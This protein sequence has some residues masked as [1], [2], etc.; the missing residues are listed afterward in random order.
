M[1][2]KQAIVNFWS[3]EYDEYDFVTNVLQSGWDF[4]FWGKN[5]VVWF[6]YEIKEF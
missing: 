2:M 5:G 1:N 6:D 3:K 4:I